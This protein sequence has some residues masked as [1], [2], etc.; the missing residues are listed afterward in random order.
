MNRKDISHYQIPATDP[1]A[2]NHPIFGAYVDGYTEEHTPFNWKILCFYIIPFACILWFIFTPFA[3][4]LV[5]A[6]YLLW[7]F[8][9]EKIRSLRILIYQGGFV[10]QIVKRSGA[11]AEIVEYD[12]DEMTGM[13]L[14]KCRNYQVIYGIRMYQRTDIELKIVKGTLPAE[15]IITGSYRNEEEKDNRY[16]FKGYVA[17]ALQRAW[18]PI[19]IEHF[20]R[21]MDVQGYG[22]FYDGKNKIEVGKGFIRV[23]KQG[24]SGSFQYTFQDGCLY[25]YHKSEEG[26]HFKGKVKPIK[27]DVNNMFDSQVFLFA[28][29]KLLGIK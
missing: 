19:A 18:L 29:D 12:F 15:T 11:I 23:G 1:L 16:N 9:V 5:V 7:Y 10:K 17:I 3:G 2:L 8:V 26:A 25:L 13:S 28:A 6:L 14:S 27:V 24:F 20:N 22:T 4:I 21:Q